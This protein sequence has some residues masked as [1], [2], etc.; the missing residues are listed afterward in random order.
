MEKS[1]IWPLRPWTLWALIVCISLGVAFPIGLNIYRRAGGMRATTT[2][3]AAVLSARPGVHI[4][5]VVRLEAAAGLNAY[6]AELLESS[7][8]MVF[9]ETP[10]QIRVALAGDSAVIMGGAA[11]IHPGAVVQVSG[12]MDGAHTLHA[13]QVVILGGY[14]RVNR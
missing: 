1:R 9:H 6:S 2:S 8:G 4:K 5:A 13:T 3:A 10:S 7:D 12:A 14:V 11:D